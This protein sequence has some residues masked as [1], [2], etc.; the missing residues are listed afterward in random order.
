MEC[1][2]QNTTTFQLIA[3]PKME[4]LDPMMDHMD[5]ELSS[6]ISKADID[7]HSF[8]SEIPAEFYE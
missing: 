7:E 8:L 1:G 4:L 2:Q 3:L 6:R 5:F